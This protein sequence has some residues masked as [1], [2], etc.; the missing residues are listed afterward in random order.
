MT[1]WLVFIDI[2][3]NKYES[4]VSLP[5]EARGNIT[6]AVIKRVTYQSTAGTQPPYLQIRFQGCLEA[7]TLTSGAREDCIQYPTTGDQSFDIYLKVK[8]ET[9]VPWFKVS[10][11]GDGLCPQTILEDR[12]Q[13]WIE[14]EIQ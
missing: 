9:F 10:I 14:L 11:L 6:S 1:K 3:P 12:V 8:N 4:T 13:V 2:P 5:L 7:F